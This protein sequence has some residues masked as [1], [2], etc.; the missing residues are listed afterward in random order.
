MAPETATILSAVSYIEDHLAE[1]LS[2]DVV[3]KVCGYSK[4]HF[5]RLFQATTGLTPA[6]Y[7]RKRR[8]SEVVRAMERGEGNIT[9]LAF[10]YG[11][12]SK[13]NFTR[14]FRK[15]HGILPTEYRSAENSLVLCAPFVP[16]VP[17]LCLTGEMV[18]RAEITL[19]V[20]PSDTEKPSDFWNR[21]N[22]DRLSAKLSGGVDTEDYGVC[23]WNPVTCRLDY[24]IGIP[25]DRAKGD[26]T[27]TEVLTIPAGLYIRFQ[28]PPVE[29]FAFIHTVHCTWAAIPDWLIA[30]GY[31]RRDSYEM[32][33]Y[34]ESSRTFS[35]EIWIPVVKYKE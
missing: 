23:R 20:Y 9:D 5:Q 18:T 29:Q 35:E 3:A 12:N 16:D 24:W 7:I 26:V 14:A 33:I 2:L 22:V 30:H 8:I 11:F 19:T 15:E 25:S 6:A 10:R 27:G 1:P 28:T 31:G 17:P 13:E 21:Y 34:R 4:F 32:E